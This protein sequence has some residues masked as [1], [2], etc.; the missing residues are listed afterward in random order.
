MDP[1]AILTRASVWLALIA[2][3]IASGLLLFGRGT[4]NGLPTTTVRWIWTAGCVFFLLHIGSAFAF[5]HHWSH[6]AAYRETA[7]QTAEL[8]GLHWGGGIYLNYLFATA[9]LADV[10]SMWLNPRG[11]VRRERW[12]TTAWHC[13]FFFMVFNG[14]VVFAHGPV[15]WLGLTICGTLAAIWL[16][17]GAGIRTDE[18]T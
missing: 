17:R 13:F 11:R 2:Y 3:A 5:F 12:M 18:S 7:K 9:W 1:G 4:R 16:W 8:T 15:R 6:E 10:L 14:A